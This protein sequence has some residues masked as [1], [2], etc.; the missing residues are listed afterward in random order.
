MFAL[1]V[2]YHLCSGMLGTAIDAAGVC[3]AELGWVVYTKAK[4]EPK[5]VAERRV[6]KRHRD[7]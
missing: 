4:A 2:T 1:K 7:E 3:S 5:P 6:S